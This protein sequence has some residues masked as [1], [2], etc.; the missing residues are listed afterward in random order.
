MQPH[1]SRLASSTRPRER[2]WLKFGRPDPDRLRTVMA[3]FTSQPAK[4]RSRGTVVATDFGQ[5]ILKLVQGRGGLSL[6]SNQAHLS[7]YDLDLRS[8][9]V[10]VLPDQPGAIPHLLV[11][12][13]KEGTVY[14]LNRDNMG[15]IQFSWRYPNCA[16]TT[17][18][19]GA[20]F[21]T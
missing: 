16:G 3:I 13:G 9:G 1:F 14:L 18:A 19:V 12:S 10:V 20:M 8:C 11:A 15:P 2:V 4:V 21:S 6:A 5:S 17:S 7:Q